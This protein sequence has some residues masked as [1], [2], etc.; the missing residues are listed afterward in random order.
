MFLSDYCFRHLPTLPSTPI[1]SWTTLQSPRSYSDSKAL[2]IRLQKISHLF[3]TILNLQFQWPLKNRR[4]PKRANSLLFRLA[5]KVYTIPLHRSLKSKNFKNLLKATVIMKSC[6]NNSS[7]T[8]IQTQI[9]TPRQLEM[10]YW[11][12]RRSMRDS[13]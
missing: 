6:S 5:T 10:N 11:N 9:S 2:M 7:M 1:L 13:R 12:T 3:L 8:N 4:L